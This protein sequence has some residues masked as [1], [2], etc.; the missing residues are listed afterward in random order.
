VA[1]HVGRPPA[2]PVAEIDRRHPPKE[3]LS[4][5]SVSSRV[6]RVWAL[7]L[8]VALL[9]TL[10]A[11]AGAGA[12]TGAVKSSI[13][14]GINNP[15][16][17]TQMP[18]FVALAKGYFKQVGIQKVKVITTDNFVAGLVGGSLDLSQGDTDQWLTAAQK[19]GKIKYLG[20]Y[21]GSEWH[22]LGVSKDIKSPS[23]LIGKK[24]TAGE[25]GGRNE[26]VL[27][28]M[29]KTIG[30]DPSKVD[31]V[32]LGGGSDARLQ[33]LVNG[34][35]DGAVIFPRHLAALKDAGGKTLFK[36]LASVPQEGIAARTDFLKDNRDTVVAFWKA[37]LKARQFIKN[38]KNRNAVLKIM[39][40]AKFEIPDD[41][42]A[43][44][45][46]EINQISKDG[47]FVPAQMTALVKSEQALGIIP[48]N[49]N[50]KKLIDLTP[51]WQAQ[52]SLKMKQNP[53]PSAVK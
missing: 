40:D 29:L 19:S 51:L 6:G 53:L 3:D 27:K 45:Q 38:P 35:V 31:F 42:A 25:R 11:T 50:W 36:A 8:L 39:R 18:I 24:V 28:T 26:F 15:N 37:T 13:T 49:L 16:Y 9:A 47:G 12:K 21:R 17:A 43:L 23:D 44:Y 14:V 5:Y 30:V 2:Q 33:A 34:Q 32:P 10:V 20:T 46:T 4:M 41:F 1:Q 22:I 52:L 7:A 48:K